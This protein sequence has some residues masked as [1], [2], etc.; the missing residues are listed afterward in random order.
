MKVAYE[1]GRR[2]WGGD[3]VELT[4]SQPVSAQCSIEYL[5]NASTSSYVTGI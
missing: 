1:S 4:K 5:A 3:D 2:N